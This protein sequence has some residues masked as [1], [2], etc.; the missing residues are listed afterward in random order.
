MKGYLIIQTILDFS[1]WFP[2]F[3]VVQGAETQNESTL[4]TYLPGSA[5]QEQLP[6]LCS[7]TAHFAGIQK[8]R[9]GAEEE[10][11]EPQHLHTD[12]PRVSLLPAPLLLSNESSNS[13]WILSRRCH[14]E[15]CTWQPALGDLRSWA[16]PGDRK[17]GRRQKMKD[18]TSFG[19]S[20]PTAVTKRSPQD[21]QKYLNI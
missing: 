19:N 20:V 1:W 18:K 9:N 4:Q 13:G 15:V 5:A 12:P 10:E 21:F 6:H 7:A 14:C 8:G 16:I 2:V 11:D 17:G 3:M